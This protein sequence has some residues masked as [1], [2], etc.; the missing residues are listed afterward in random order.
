MRT[1]QIPMGSV[2]RETEA[3]AKIFSMGRSSPYRRGGV[4]TVPAA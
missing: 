1:S 2:T 4:R 3:R